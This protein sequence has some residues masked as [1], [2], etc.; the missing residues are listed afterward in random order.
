ML[1]N[2]K[3]LLQRVRIMMVAIVTIMGIGSAFAMKAPSSLATTW[4]VVATVG[5]DYVVTAS[6]GSCNF[7]PETA[8]TIKS[9]V[10]PDSQNHI[11][12]D[13]AALDRSGDF[14]QSS[15]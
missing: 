14:M 6:A 2:K 3:N 13:D 15:R 8:C 11:S 5:N 9:E 4:N 1:N 7:N 10:A 12:K